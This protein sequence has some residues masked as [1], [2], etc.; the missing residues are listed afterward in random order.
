MR[1]ERGG[2]N[3]ENERKRDREIEKMREKLEINRE[4]EKM[5]EEIER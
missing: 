2:V 1:E 5:R 3:K 4:M